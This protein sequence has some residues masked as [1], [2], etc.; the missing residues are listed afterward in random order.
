[1]PRQKN[2]PASPRLFFRCSFLP[3]RRVGLDSRTVL[4]LG[5][6]GLIAYFMLIPGSQ[7]R[8]SMCRWK[9]G[10]HLAPRMD[11]WTGLRVAEID[12][13]AGNNGE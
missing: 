8:E 3:T 4:V 12:G 2:E 1:L 13:V 11:A 9:A 5:P 6:S 7:V 10:V